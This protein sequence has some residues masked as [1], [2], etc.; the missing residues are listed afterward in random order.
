RPGRD[1]RIRCPGCRRVSPLAWLARRWRSSIRGVVENGRVQHRGNRG[2]TRLRSQNRGTQAARHPQP[3]GSRD[4]PM[5]KPQMPGDDFLAPEQARQ[6]DQLCDQFE[7][8]WKHGHRPAIEPFLGDARGDDRM[9]LL[10]ELLLVDL[11]YRSRNREPI[12]VDDY[13]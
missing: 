7:T 3:L 6:L 10:R 9:T 2:E 1:S 5:S 12:V 13:L 11:S 4:S 8:A